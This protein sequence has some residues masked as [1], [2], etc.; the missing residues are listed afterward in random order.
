[1]APQCTLMNRRERRLLWL[2][3]SRAM[4]LLPVPVSPVSSTVL[5]VP[6]TSRT[7]SNTSRM[8]GLLVWARSTASPAQWRSRR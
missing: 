1:M 5:R 6:A 8:R 2:W 4:R 7:L 3:M